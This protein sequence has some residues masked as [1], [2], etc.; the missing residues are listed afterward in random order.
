M[1]L[2]F[3]SGN[4]GLLAGGGT[5]GLILWVLK[6]VPNE[7]IYNA[8]EKLFKGLGVAMTLGLGKFKLTKKYWNNT[9]E[10]WVIDLIENTVGA[11]VS[12]FV[13]GLRS[14]K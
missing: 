5:A 11:A 2:S 3:L 10:P 14:D 1:D 13:K 9:I 12:G 6:K 7:K 8:V 4:V